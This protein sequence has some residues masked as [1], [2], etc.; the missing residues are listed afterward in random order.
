MTV[1]WRQRILEHVA[2]VGTLDL[3]KISEPMRQRL[4]DLGMEEPP[5]VEVDADRVR[6]TAAGRAIAVGQSPQGEK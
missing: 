2:E 3:R 1:F 4:I 6:L 5:L